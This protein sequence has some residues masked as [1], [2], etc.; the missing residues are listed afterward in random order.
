MGMW[1]NDRL[2]WHGDDQDKLRPREEWIGGGPAPSEPAGDEVEPGAWNN[3]RR[4]YKWLKDAV[5]PIGSWSF[6][7][8]DLSEGCGAIFAAIFLLVLGAIAIFL[9][10]MAVLDIVV[11]MVAI[12]AAVATVLLRRFRDMAGS[13]HGWRLA[14]AIEGAV[15]LAVLIV[16]AVRRLL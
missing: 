5:A 11:A 13:L 1:P 16:L 7:G 9:L 8:A 10:L 6:E 3:L 2:Q 4:G 15:I 14:L 12:L